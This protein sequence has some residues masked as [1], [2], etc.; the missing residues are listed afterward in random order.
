MQPL[1]P[2]ASFHPGAPQRVPPSLKKV[3]KPCTL[4][5]P[6][7]PRASWF[8]LPY[9]A[10]KQPAFY[11][12]F[13]LVT[14]NYWA[15]EERLNDMKTWSEEE[16]AAYREVIDQNARL[17]WV[18]ACLLKRRLMR[19]TVRPMNEDDI[20]TLEPPRQRIE[21]YDW[22]ARKL[23]IYEASTVARDIR[24]CLLQR[25][26]MFPCPMSPR[27]LLTNQTLSSMQALSVFHQLRQTRKAL[28]WS[29]TAFEDGEF[30]LP[31]FTA[32]FAQPL[33]HEVLR[34]LSLQPTHDDTIEIVEDFIRDEHVYRG[35][36]FP[37]I[38]YQWAL[39]HAPDAPRIREWRRIAFRHHAIEIDIADETERTKQ[40]E[41]ELDEPTEK[42]CKRPIELVI[43]RNKWKLAQLGGGG[44]PGA[45]SDL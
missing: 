31:R 25:D 15:A 6:K 2:Q 42:L 30:C 19:R 9:S 36:P 24:E 16:R 27:N 33:R 43:M 5:R 39:K 14:P 23:Y 7:E 11:F 41:K 21:V 17:R 12:L 37:T 38:T 32:R 34:T 8:I 35:I 28:H 4:Q 13:T 20:V 1:L 3:P 45:S 40:Q 44:G 22:P 10:V 29:F 26:Y 18:T